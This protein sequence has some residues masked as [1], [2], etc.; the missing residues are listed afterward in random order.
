MHPRLS[1]GER[2]AR[3]PKSGVREWSGSYR[4]VQLKSACRSAQQGRVSLWFRNALRGGGAAEVQ[5]ACILVSGFSHG[6][7]LVRKVRRAGVEWNVSISPIEVGL[8]E[9]SARPREDVFCDAL[10]GWGAAEVGQFP[11]LSLRA[12]R[13]VNPPQGRRAR[14]RVRHCRGEGTEAYVMGPSGAAP[15][16]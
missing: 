14:G 11:P 6:L 13:R 3:S 7:A 10:R 4:S 15:G 8:P 2:I 12:R 5:R 16:E 1:V 9:R